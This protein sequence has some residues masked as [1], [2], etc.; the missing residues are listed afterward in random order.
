MLLFEL[1]ELYVILGMNFLT[2]Y[3][4][5]FYC[6]NKEVVMKELGKSEVKFVVVTKVGLEN[7]ISALKAR[8]LIRKGHIAN[9]ASI[10]DT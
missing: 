9:F 1:D 6:S 5:V 3:L 4:V 7:I 10:I 2:K 8:K